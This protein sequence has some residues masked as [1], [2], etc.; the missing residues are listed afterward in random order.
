MNDDEFKKQVRVMARRTEQ[1]EGHCAFQFDL[2]RP[3]VIDMSSPRRVKVDK[4]RKGR[5]D[6][7]AVPAVIVLPYPQTQYLSVPSFNS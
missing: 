1:M 5:V 3:N 7:G 4:M 2:S 6:T